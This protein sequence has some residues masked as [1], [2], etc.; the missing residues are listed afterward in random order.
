VVVLSTVRPG[1][2]PI[3]LRLARAAR[4]VGRAFDRALE[5]AGGSLPVWL[6]LLNLKIRPDA[7]Q[8]ELAAAIG[9]R[10]ATLTHH[11]NA[12]ERSGLLARRR[13]ENNRRVHVIELTSAGRAAFTRLARVAAAFD[14]R[15]RAGL[16][17]PQIAE[18]DRL[19]TQ[20]VANIDGDGPDTAPWAGVISQPRESGRKSAVARANSAGSGRR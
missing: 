7:N 8:R 3:G 17:E 14:H 5:E 10:E 4:L 20:L 15:L 18:L 13:D 9:V 6:V 1:T 16:D 2:P 19:L 12:M 11:L